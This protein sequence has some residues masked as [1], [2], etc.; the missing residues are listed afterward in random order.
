MGTLPLSRAVAYS[1]AAHAVIAIALV[2]TA[3]KS[4]EHSAPELVDIELAPPAPPAEAL[5]AEAAKPI[6]EGTEHAM[7]KLDE[8]DVGDEPIA[9]D[10]GIDAMAIAAG[11]GSGSDNGSAAMGSAVG[12][13]G[14]TELGSAGSDGVAGTDDAPAVAGAPTSPGTAANLLAYMPPGH[15]LAVLVRF[16]RLRGTE[17]AKRTED[18]FRHMP[19]Y[20][21]L[22]GTR[23]ADIADK[24]DT[25][26]I[27]TP[28]PK[29]AIATTLVMHTQLARAAIRDL[30]GTGITWSTATGGMLGT[31]LGP[32]FPGDKR[33]MLSPWRGWYVLAQPADLGNLAAKSGGNLDTREVG[34]SAPLPAW[35]AQVRSIEHES[36]DDAKIGPALVLTLSGAPLG[37]TPAR[38]GRYK[39]PDVGLGV[40][41]LAVPQRLS[42]AMELVQQGWLVRGNISFASEADAAEFAASLA[43]AQHRLVLIDQL[44]HVL[45]NN[46]V[47]GLIQNLSLSR[48]GARVSYATSISIADGRAVLAAARDSLQ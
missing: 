6:D 13:A 5:P 2:I 9:H 23:D 8:P 22:F 12:V 36:G 24:L 18:L 48:T 32:G 19:D 47:L 16:D 14:A 40:S 44:S 34:A 7:T 38:T 30:L 10:A 46:H 29:S 17:W 35:L 27:S 33:V 3:N 41:S 21:G 28:E 20:G 1:I 11:S 39:L 43:T 31:R 15:V 42:L 45:A 4:A 26:A 37:T 25:L